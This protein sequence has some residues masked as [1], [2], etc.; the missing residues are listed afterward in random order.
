MKL[1]ANRPRLATMKRA[2]QVRKLLTGSHH[3][4]TLCKRA[5]SW[6]LAI[7]AKCARAPYPMGLNVYL[8]RRRTQPT[9]DQSTEPMPERSIRAILANHF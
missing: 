7:L 9:D 3:N 1:L 2:G 6:L 8:P 4:A 5:T